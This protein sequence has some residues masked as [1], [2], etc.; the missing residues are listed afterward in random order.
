MD[1]VFALKVDTGMGI[2][3]NKLTAKEAKNGMEN[4][5]YANQVLILMEVF[6]S[7]V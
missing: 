6:A 4:N 2:I 7:D 3:V 1:N 5:A